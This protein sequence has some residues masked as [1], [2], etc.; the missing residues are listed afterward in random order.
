MTVKDFI[1]K[2]INDAKG[3]YNRGY[4]KAVNDF[5]HTKHMNSTIR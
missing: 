2:F 5:I 3:K 4:T 1:L